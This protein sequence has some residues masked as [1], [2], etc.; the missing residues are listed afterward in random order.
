ML[1]PGERSLEVAEV[2]RAVRD[3]EPSAWVVPHR[4]LR[5]VIKRDRGLNAYGLQVPH[6]L[7]YT[8]SGETL[9]TI[10]DPS[11]LEIT[12]PGPMP[13]KVIL[14]ARPLP[15]ELARTPRQVALT[16][17]WRL[18]F[19]ARVHAALEE[20]LSSW[21]DVDAEI[22]ERVAAIGP[23]EFLEIRSV[24]KQEGLLLPPADDLT[25]YNEF[26]AHYLELRH[27]TPSLLPH[28]FPGLGD[29][30][31]IDALLRVDVDDL[32]LLASTRLAGAPDLGLG[33]ISL[34]L[35]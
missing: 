35:D 14:V 4:I 20:T 30:A 2:E 21:K 3:A 32:A 22:R 23:M 13:S 24:L 9:G 10:V 34:N 8:I 29:P 1:D 7:V 11:E 31:V 26:A 16:D 18:L 25:V 27:F 6:R 28:T 19:H 33:A 5:R 15:E 17:Y 12:T